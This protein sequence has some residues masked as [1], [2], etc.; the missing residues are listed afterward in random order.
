MKAR[1]RRGFVLFL[2]LSLLLTGCWNSRE[3]NTLAIVSG[4][5]IDKL[6]NQ[7]G[8]RVSFQIVLPSSTS[9]KPESSVGGAGIIINTAT[10]KTLF[11]ALRK[12]SKKTSRQ[13]FFA[14]CQLVILG[15]E[16]AKDGL[17]TVFDIFE[18]SHELR[19]N[20]AVLVSRGTDAASILKILLPADNVPSI[21]V[22]KKNQITSKVWGENNS[23]DVMEV[24]QQ[25]TGEG[26]TIISGVR[27][28]GDKEG[29]KKKKDLEQTELPSVV[30]MSGM[31]VFKKGKLTRWVDGHEARGTLT[32]LDKLKETVVNIDNQDQA[33]AIAVNIF[34]SKTNVKVSMRGGVPHFQVSILEEGNITETKLDVNLSDRKTIAILERKLEKKTK[35]EV[36][37]TIQAAQEKES[38]PFKFGNE[39][40]RAHPAEW[41]KV[42]ENWDSAF[43]SG[44]LDVAV[45]AHIRTTGMRLNPYSAK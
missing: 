16:L 28:I 7:E 45:E 11:G 12:A 15:E 6:D 42:G 4:L 21:G 18:R 17:G 41:K 9:S 33:E 27:I 10:D 32:V 38:D 36:I 25:L 44:V 24:I 22:V 34:S 31:G 30:V 8:Y 5:G 20:T 13:L 43:A 35:D 26:D 3:L 19:L 39:L 23:V 37:R 40:K 29:G 2:C 1:W 14:H